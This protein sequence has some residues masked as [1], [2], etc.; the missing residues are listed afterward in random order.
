[1]L[2]SPVRTSIDVPRTVQQ[3]QSYATPVQ[4]ALKNPSSVISSVSSTANSAAQTAANNPQSLMTR[5]RNLDHNTMMSVGV[6]T[7]ETLGFFSIGTM[8]GRMKIVG[9]RSDAPHAGH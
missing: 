2:A 6:V 4:N 7:A 5:L 1:M 9:Y 3:L 8:L